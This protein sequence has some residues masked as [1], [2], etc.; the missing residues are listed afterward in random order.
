MLEWIAYCELEPFDEVREDQRTASIVQAVWNA[1]RWANS[2]RE[3]PYQP[4]P[5]E[6]FRL[7][8][9]EDLAQPK[10]RTQT[11]EE[12]KRMAELWVAAY[13]TP[14]QAA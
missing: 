7:T 6:T 12:Q 3:H 9:G 2:S 14:Q 4:L 5:L 11:W 8:F 13:N 10:P 1:A